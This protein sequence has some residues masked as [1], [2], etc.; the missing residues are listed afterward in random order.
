M[1]SVFPHTSDY[2]TANRSQSDTTL[3]CSAYAF[4]DDA[5]ASFARSKQRP[6]VTIHSF[7]GRRHVLS[8][9]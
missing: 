5:A 2:S 4:M 9:F 1:A 3:M 7:I 8:N 6:K